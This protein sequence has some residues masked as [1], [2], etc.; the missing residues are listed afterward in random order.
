MI[1]LPPG[2]GRLST[3]DTANQPSAGS[4][5]PPDAPIP[6]APSTQVTPIATASRMATRGKEPTSRENWKQPTS[7]SITPSRNNNAYAPP[8]TNAWSPRGAGRLGKLF[9]DCRLYAAPRL[10]SVGPAPRP[11][12]PPAPHPPGRP[13]PARPVTDRRHSGATRSHTPP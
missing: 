10:P 9:T 11:P 1:T 3:M 12:P 8:V 4:R 13:G 5:A 2:E 6:A 7:P